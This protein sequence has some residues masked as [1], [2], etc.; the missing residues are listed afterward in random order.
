VDPDLSPWFGSPTDLPV[1][2]YPEDAWTYS[3]DNLFGAPPAPSDGGLAPRYP[4]EAGGMSGAPLPARPEP[5]IRD[6][7]VPE[8]EAPVSG[9]SMDFKRKPPEGPRR[10]GP[11][12]PL[13]SWHQ[14]NPD[15]PHFAGQVPLEYAPASPYPSYAPAEPGGMTYD[16]MAPPLTAPMAHGPAAHGIPDLATGMIFPSDVPSESRPEA[17][18][19]GPGPVDYATSPEAPGSAVFRPPGLGE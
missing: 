8:L 4:T 18:L 7:V 14:P 3:A 13:K 2:S 19:P 15:Y 17:P 6:V 1:N 11:V 16:N 5:F 10:P 12:G 9:F